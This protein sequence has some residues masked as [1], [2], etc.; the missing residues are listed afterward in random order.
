MPKITSLKFLFFIF[1]FV[2]YSSISQAFSIAPEET[3][4]YHPANWADSDSASNDAN[5]A[6]KHKDLRLLG[7]AGRGS[8]IPGVDATAIQTYRNI[9]GVRY[10]EEFSD[11]IRDRDQLAQMKIARQYALEYNKVILTHCQLTD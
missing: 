6:I 3:E 8:T 1:C 2:A 10:F 9:C 5:N 4:N 7:F 11:V